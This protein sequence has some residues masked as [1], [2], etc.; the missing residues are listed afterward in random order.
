VEDRYAADCLDL[1]YT[2][3]VSVDRPFRDT[4]LLSVLHIMMF[5]LLGKQNKITN[6][7]IKNKSSINAFPNFD[8][9]GTVYFGTHKLI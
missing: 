7:T 5:D 4:I 8:I 1:N 2:T 6:N 3:M 9:F